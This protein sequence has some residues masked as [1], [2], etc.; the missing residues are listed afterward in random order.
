MAYVSAAGG[1]EGSEC[2]FCVSLDDDDE[3]AHVVSR[4]PKVFAL[5]NAFPYNTGHL[6]VA[7]T[8]HVAELD[9]LTPEERTDLMELV[10]RA[11]ATIGNVTGAHGFNVGMNL[12]QV[13]GAGIPGHLH[14]HVVPRWEGDTS[15][16]PVVSDTKVLPETLDETYAK[17]RPAFDT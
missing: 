12:G 8:R 4:G 14:V 13:A 9:G 7:P 3:V 6:M 15:F 17:L 2:I 11:V 10:T 5:L 1:D 16:M